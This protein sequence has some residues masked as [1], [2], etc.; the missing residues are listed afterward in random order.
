MGKMSNIML[1]MSIWNNLI[2]NSIEKIRNIL[3]NGTEC[4]HDNMESSEETININYY[5]Q[6]HSNG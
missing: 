1:K 4:E 5:T 6:R 2:L 3:E